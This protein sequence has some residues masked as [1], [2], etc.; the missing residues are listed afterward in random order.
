MVPN[1]STEKSQCCLHSGG[2]SSAMQSTEQKGV[3]LKWSIRMKRLHEATT[4]QLLGWMW[5]SLSCFGLSAPAVLWEKC[6]QQDFGELEPGEPVCLSQ[7]A[8]LAWSLASTSATGLCCLPIS[9]PH[10]LHSRG[11]KMWR[12]AASVHWR[13]EQ[14]CFWILGSLGLICN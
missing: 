6:C 3:G 4:N 9:L 1:A 12:F 13:N 10:S 11:H 2:C 8:D 7:G 5:T 14:V